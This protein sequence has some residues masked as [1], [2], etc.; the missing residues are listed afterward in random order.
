M[1]VGA[2]ARTDPIK[3]ARYMTIPQRINVFITEMAPRPVCD[4]CI[5]EAV[6]MKNKGIHAVQTTGALGTTSDFTRELGVCSMCNY[7]RMVIYA[8]SPER[9]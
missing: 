5:A 7:Q 8:N 4:R 6:G 2:P 1:I 3:E 9:Q